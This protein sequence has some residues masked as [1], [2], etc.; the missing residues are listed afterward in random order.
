MA[1]DTK[2]RLIDAALALFAERGFGQVTIQDIAKRA[3]ANIAAVNYHF[4]DKARFHAEVI[5]TQLDRRSGPPPELADVPD[6]PAAAL[7]AFVTWFLRR[8]CGPANEAPLQ[9]ILMHEQVHPGES[10]VLDEIVE[11]VMR[12]QHD[13]LAEVVAAL[14]PSDASPDTI[15]RFTFSVISQCV[16]YKHAWPVMKRLHPE[17]ELDDTELAAIADHVSR[18]C[19][20]GLAAERDRHA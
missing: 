11:R 18:L 3:G 12:P 7:T 4:G 13:R 14:L 9:H 1:A 10:P 15:R 2:D 6:D 19:L 17:L 16:S 5:R 20:A 8:I